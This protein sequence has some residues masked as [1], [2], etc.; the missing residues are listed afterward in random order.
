[1]PRGSKGRMKDRHRART[2]LTALDLEGIEA[3]RFLSQSVAEARRL[4]REAV[5]IL[6]MPSLLLMENA[7]R[8][9]AIQARPLLGNG[10]A[11]VLAGPGNNGGDG[12]ALA[13]FLSPRA[14]VVLFSDPDP[15]RCPDAALQRRILEA[16]GLEIHRAA[17]PADL[18]RLAGEVELLVDALLGT[19]LARAPEGRMAE[20]ISWMNETPLPVLSL[21]VP[22]GLDAD[23][24]GA[25]D[26]CVHASLTVTFAR[27]KRG[28]MEGDGPRVSGRVIVGTLG[29]PEDWVLDWMRPEDET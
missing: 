2:N 20:W 11:L 17:G 27:P 24:G 26:P 14:R 4:D 13:R 19:G 28:L 23:G 6:G 16:S 3:E 5:E 9:A 21:D 22:S 12:M 10:K 25:F 29:L 7:A 15:K 1:M 8:S 18:C